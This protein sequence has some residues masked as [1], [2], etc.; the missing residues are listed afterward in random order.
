MKNNTLLLSTLVGDVTA[1]SSE[2]TLM[3]RV[4]DAI[5]HES[6]E[7]YIAVGLH[8]LLTSQASRTLGVAWYTLLFQAIVN[9]HFEVVSVHGLN[10]FSDRLYRLLDKHGLTLDDDLVDQLELALDHLV[11]IYDFTDDDRLLEEDDDECA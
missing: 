2:L 4:F 7:Y 9:E 3:S 5:Q 1:F 6:G 11:D 8:R 10:R